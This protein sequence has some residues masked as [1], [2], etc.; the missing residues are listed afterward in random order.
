MSTQ[1]RGSP[2]V[3]KDVWATL[4]LL[5]KTA[6]CPGGCL[7]ESRPCHIC[8]TRDQRKSWRELS[9]V[10]LQTG[11]SSESKRAKCKELKTRPGWKWDRR[12]DPVSW[13]WC[14]AMT[15]DSKSHCEKTVP[16]SSPS[17]LRTVELPGPFTY[18]SLIWFEG[19]CFGHS[20]IGAQVFSTLFWFLY[21]ILFLSSP[22]GLRI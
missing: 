18:C 19:S 5:H 7:P 10:I 16:A 11:N 8:G 13:L 22:E 14:N 6:G 20:F 15:S 2:K 4:S 1:V 21:T 9:L 12:E 17:T 3:R